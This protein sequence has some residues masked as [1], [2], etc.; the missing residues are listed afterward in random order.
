MLPSLSVS[1]LG[2]VIPLLVLRVLT[3]FAFLRN[4]RICSTD[5]SGAG[6]GAAT[7]AAVCA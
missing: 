3:T 2:A 6:A 1:R 4:V 7:G 5:N